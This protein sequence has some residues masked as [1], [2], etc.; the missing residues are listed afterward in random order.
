[1]GPYPF[2]ES[3]VTQIL[4]DWFS[5]SAELFV[6]LDRPHSGASGDFYIL[7]TYPQYE[8]LIMKAS[9]GSICYILRDKQ[10]PIRGLVDAALI[11]QALDWF[12]DGDYYII[13]EPSFTYPQTLC[14][15]GDGNTLQELERELR[16]LLGTEVWLGNELGFPNEYWKENTAQNAL[17]I[18][19]PK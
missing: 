7:N 2:S 13:I 5:A 14:L 16:E 10:L 12:K 17:I 11:Q 3:I 4:Q 8:D 18:T 6:A 1:M 9:P 19:K 15:V